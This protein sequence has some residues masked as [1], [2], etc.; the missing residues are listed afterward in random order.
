MEAYLVAFGDD[1]RPLP[2]TVRILDEIVTE[3]VYLCLDSPRARTS[4]MSSSLDST[5][6]KTKT[7]P[8]ITTS[9]IIETCHS[10]ALCAQISHRAKIKVDDFKFALRKDPK[11]LGRVTELL[12]M[13]R[14][15]KKARKAFDD[16]G[17]GAVGK[18]KSATVGKGG[19]K[20]G[21]DE[22]D[23]GVGGASGAGGSARGSA[24]KSKRTRS[25]A[26]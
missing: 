17:E 7:D 25:V 14:T 6:I 10:A 3:L 13:D 9:F 18:E 11:K 15:I 24:K 23:D 5:N 26:E 22:E 4:P 19:E 12:S 2:E 1:P 20:R 8:L 16:E 21:R